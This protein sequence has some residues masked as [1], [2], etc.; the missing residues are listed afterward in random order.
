MSG[1]TTTSSTLLNSMTCVNRFGKVDMQIL[2]RFIGS[3]AK[4]EAYCPVGDKNWKKVDGALKAKL[5][6]EIEDRFVIPDGLVYITQILK[7]ANKSWKQYKYSLKKDYYKPEEKTETQITT[8]AVPQH[9]IICK[10]WIKLVRYWYS[11]EGKED[12]H[13]VKMSL[14]ALWIKTHSGKDGTFLPNT[15]TEDFVD[16]AK[17]M[18]ESLKNV[19]P[20]KSQQELENEAFEDTMR[21]GKVPECLVDH[22]LGVRK[23]DVYGVH[24]VVRKNGY[25]KVR[26]RTVVMENVKEEV[27]AINKKNKTLEKENGK[28]QDQV[29]ENNWLLKTLIGQ[30]AQRVGQVRTGTASTKALDCAQQVL[31]MAHKR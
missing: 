30:F 27:S 22:G 17:A 14:L 24:G 3:L 11:D 15:L 31:G 1:L 7:C 19:D 8:E 25:G 2:V 26:H 18:V 28:L 12:E 4:M 5:V 21:G 9:G 13:G 10:E 6:Q 23:S 29:K 20:S 16:D